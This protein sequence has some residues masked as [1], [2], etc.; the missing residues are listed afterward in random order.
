MKLTI[1]TATYNRVNLL[2]RLY[3]SLI[4]QSNYNFE[5]LIVDDDSNDD[6]KTIVE[7]WINNAPFK[8]RYYKQLHGGKH[9]ALNKGFELAQGEYFF[10][11]D[12]DDWLT[13]NAVDFIYSAIEDIKEENSIAGFS[14]LRISNNNILG[15]VPKFENKEYIDATNLER[16][17]YNLNGDKAEIYK[18]RILLEHPFP[19]YDNEFFVT[20][21]VCWNAIAYEGYKVR[22]YNKVIYNCNYLENG[23]TKSGANSLEG[24]IKNYY[25]YCYYVKQTISHTSVIGNPMILKEY[26]KVNKILKKSIK[27]RAENIGISTTYSRFLWLFILMGY[28]KKIILKISRKIGVLYE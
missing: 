26:L 17:K 12:S 2:T 27:E 21:A 28:T 23:L 10:I 1:F 19:E 20:E 22:W 9:R 3:Q 16:D 6:T 15:G 13:K 7:N 14:G 25:G 5:W 4:D 11:V 18:T 24:H 8:I